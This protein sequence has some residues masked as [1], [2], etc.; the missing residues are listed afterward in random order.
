MPEHIGIVACSAEGAALCYTT[1][2][3]EGAQL[4]GAHNHPEVSVHTHPL[5]EYMERIYRNDWRGVGELMLSSAIKLA[6]IGANFLACPDNT[7]HQAFPCIES[8]S[9][10][11]W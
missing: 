5:A 3:I 1:I 8:R 4:L 7:S 10:L 11:P 9:P 2:C 6:S